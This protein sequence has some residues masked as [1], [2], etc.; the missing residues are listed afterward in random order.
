LTGEE[1]LA[2]R[3]LRRGTIV[4]RLS[5]LLAA[6]VAISAPAAAQGPCDPAGGLA[7]VC[8][9]T[10]AED[11]VQVPGTPWIIASGL[12]EGA[13]AG[14]HLYLV[15][16][17]DR[18]VQ[19]LLPGHVAYKQDSA[20]F[21]AC[22]GAPDETRF[23]AH[24]LSLRAGAA[25]QDTLYV[26]H[27]GE[28][29]S[30]EVFTVEAGSAVPTLTWVGC[31]LYPAGTLGNG[32]AA[33]PGGAFA[34]SEFLDTGDPTAAEKLTA[35]QP[36]GGLLIWR[37]GT[38]W[39][40]VPAAAAISADNGVAASPDGRYLF[41]AGTGDE[42]VVRLALDGTPGGTAAEPVVIRTGFHTDNLRWGSDG[43]LYAAGARDSVAN[44]FACAPGTAERCTSPFS[45]LKIDPATLQAREALRHPGGPGFGAASTALL[46]G[47]EYWLGTPHGDRIAIAPAD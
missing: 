38:G 42:T 17:Q 10:N 34:A 22:P 27:H 43:F 15:N 28:R 7:F 3:R 33:L 30:V 36:E 46:I 29:E 21:G 1:P 6:A 24:G 19:G 26:V 35:G 23:S 12:A 8:G 2:A 32:V 44:L 11:M 18:S 20:T 47:D 25:S 9:L 4:A 37:P 39:E 5:I 16:A 13:Q 45:V 31:V 41:V 40:D 14:G